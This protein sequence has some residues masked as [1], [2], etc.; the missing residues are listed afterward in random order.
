MF[1]KGMNFFLMS[2]FL[3]KMFYLQPKSN[4]KDSYSS[5]PQAVAHN[6]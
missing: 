6:G 3:M 4:Q 2:E 1:D 5:D